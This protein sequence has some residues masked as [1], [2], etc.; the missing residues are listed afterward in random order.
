MFQIC[1]R[2]RHCRRCLVPLPAPRAACISVDTTLCALLACRTTHI[3]IGPAQV[4]D[5]PGLKQRLAE[6]EQAAA[7]EDLWE[8]RG[9]ATAVLQVGS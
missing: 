8:Q 2:R 6:L 1:R 3:L 9:K 5:L 7:A 4:A